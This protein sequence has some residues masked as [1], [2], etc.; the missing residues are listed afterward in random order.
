M[1]SQKPKDV[2]ERISAIEK[3][4]KARQKFHQ[5]AKI[6]V[7]SASSDENV[8]IVLAY[9]CDICGFRS[10]PVVR[11]TDGDISNSTF[12]NVGRESVFHDLRKLMSIETE[13]LIERRENDV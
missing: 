4:A 5:Q 13:N 11:R 9:L 7:N 10:N 12:Y 1:E 8:R 2:T 3:Q 6:A